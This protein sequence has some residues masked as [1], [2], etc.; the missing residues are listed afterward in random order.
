MNRPAARA[1]LVGLVRRLRR[2][3]SVIGL[4]PQPRCGSS[5]APLGRQNVMKSRLVLSVLAALAAAIVVRAPAS[6]ATLDDVKKNG[7]VQCGTNV[8]LLGFASP[9][10]AGNWKGFDID[11]CR[12]IAAAIFNDP[13]AVKFTPLTAPQRFTALQSGEIDLLIRNTT[14][15]MSRETTLGLEF[16]P[17][18]YYDG[19]GF[20]V[21]KASKV[22]SALQLKG[23]TICVQAGTTT[24]LNLADYFKVNNLQYTPAVFQTA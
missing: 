22:T 8:G 1:V 21:K 9:D 15:T 16:A 7:F 19:Q 11:H 23:A 6:A 20:M 3:T 5:S 2:A 13:N 14:A 4:K 18:N 10:N 24:E 17:P 12:A